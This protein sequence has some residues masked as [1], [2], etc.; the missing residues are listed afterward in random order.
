MKTK[1]TG[2]VV[3]GI[4]ASSLLAACGTEQVAVAKPARI[5][6]VSAVV[7]DTLVARVLEASGSARP[8][9]EADLSTRLMGRVLTVAVHEGQRV[10]AG[11]LLL[12]LDG[13]DLD[14][15]AL[16]VNAGLEA[17]GAQV[18]LAQTQ[19]RR[20]RALYADSA[21][22]KVSLDQAETELER[23]RAGAAM[24]RSQEGEL[25][26][27]RGYTRLVAPFAGKIV[28][29]SVDPGAM[30]AP[31]MTL[32][33]L[34]DASV[35]RVS[36]S[37]TTETARFVKAGDVVGARLDG[38]PV[39]ARVEGV[40]P[41]GT[42]N[43]ALVNALVENARDSF[44]SGAVATLELP[45]GSRMVRVVPN[46]ALFREGDLVGVWV[47]KERGDIRRWIRT[48]DT[49]GDK[50]EVLSGLESG[51]TLVVSASSVARL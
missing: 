29:R 16:G 49:M 1:N 18:A 9:L 3:T 38:R 12:R 7:K 37:T 51:D 42:G 32:L 14:A 11:S 39:S 44:P 19:V 46:A 48:G 34:E 31:G 2:L 13:A 45:R 28:A 50:V 27:H 4:V 17:S 6:G 10:A 40:V 41:T 21:V 43:L 26:S 47:R 30:A 5:D 8:H 23:A 15:R 24:A 35:L 36:V 25:E 20:M 33:R 22:A